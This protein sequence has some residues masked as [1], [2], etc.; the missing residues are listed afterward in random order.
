MFHLVNG[1]LADA[2]DQQA[3]VLRQ[4]FPDLDFRRFQI[5]LDPVVAI[6]D[7]AGIPVLT[8]LGEKLARMILDDQIDE[9]TLRSPRTVR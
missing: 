2:N 3:R 6:D 1:F 4:F 7:P 5:D 8:G 9:R